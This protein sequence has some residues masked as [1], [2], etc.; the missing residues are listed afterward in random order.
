[1]K[2]IADG[3]QIRQMCDRLA[4]ELGDAMRD[5]R[6]DGPWAFVGLRSRGDLL[7][8]RLTERLEPDYHGVLDVA[9]YRDDL[10]RMAP[11]LTVRPTDLSFPMDGTN[12][13]LIDDVLMSGRTSRAA[14]QSLMDFGRPR[15]IR[16]LVLVDRGGRELPIAADFVGMKHTADA[17]QV[18]EVQ[19]TPTDASDR[20]MV[21]AREPDRAERH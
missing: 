20:I 19:M 1:M 7:A 16:L 2:V 21:G 11:G 9:L 8:E 15:V 12:V 13:V 17:D 10:S 14:M 6:G 4:Q 18:I 5:D 3:E